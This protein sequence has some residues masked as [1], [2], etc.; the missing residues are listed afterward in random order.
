MPPA[1]TSAHPPTGRIAAEPG[2]AVVPSNTTA[3]ATMAP[4]PTHEA[5][6][7][8]LSAMRPIDTANIA[9]SAPIPSSHARVNGEKYA[10]VGS[11][12]V[13]LMDQM[14]EPITVAVTPIWSARSR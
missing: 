6:V 7:R 9:T 12:P 1:S 3:D 2:N 11:D 14:S 5:I 8:K 13:W 4:R 10:V